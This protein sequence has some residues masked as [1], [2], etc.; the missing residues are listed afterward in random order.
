MS[1]LTDKLQSLAENL[2]ADEQKTLLDYAEFM[3]ERSTHQVETVSP[4]PLEILRPAEETVVGAMKRLSQTYPMLN[5]DKLL[6]NAS[7]LMSEHIMQGK[8]A[9][10][11]IDELQVMFEK[12]YQDYTDDSK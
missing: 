11:V 9:L 6:H 10:E 5:M 7:G 1:K 12:H 4:V 2:N 8:A 3:V